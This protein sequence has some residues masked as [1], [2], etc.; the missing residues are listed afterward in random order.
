MN[1]V[2]SV[3]TVLWTELVSPP[4]N[5]YVEALIPNVTAFGDG[6]YKEVIKVR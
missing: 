6:A 4:P 2:I 5:T 1:S 3:L